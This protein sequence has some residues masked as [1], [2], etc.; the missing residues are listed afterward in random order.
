MYIYIYIHKTWMLYEWVI[1]FSLTTH[2]E[3]WI[4]DEAQI[5][6][7]Q[8]SRNKPSY[9]RLPS[10]SNGFSASLKFPNVIGKWYPNAPCREHLPTFPLECGHFSPNMEHL[11]YITTAG[12]WKKHPVHLLLKSS[13]TWDIHLPFYP[14]GCIR[15]PP[16]RAPGISTKT[17]ILTQR[18]T[19]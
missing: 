6:H 10:D 8:I 2:L 9:Q 5:Y 7:S 1:D 14:P 13:K 12:F 4:W 15:G 17:L 18:E 3:L 16:N 19:T 11:G